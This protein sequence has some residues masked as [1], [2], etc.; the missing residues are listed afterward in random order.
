M[1]WRA[2]WDRNL[3][4]HCLRHHAWDLW[5]PTSP[6]AACSVAEEH[7]YAPVGADGMSVGCKTEQR[8][9]GDPAGKQPNGPTS[10]HTDISIIAGIITCLESASGTQLWNQDR[11]VTVGS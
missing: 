1:S 9:E 6:T 5:E 7:A 10:R 3:L 8:V 4:A 11:K 2:F